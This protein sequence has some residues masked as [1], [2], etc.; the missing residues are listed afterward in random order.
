M[1]NQEG[2]GGSYNSFFGY[3]AGK[4]TTGTEN[5]CLGYGSGLLNTAAGGNTFFGHTAGRDNQGSGS[6]KNTYL[7]WQSGRLV[8]SGLGNTYMGWRSGNNS[9]QQNSNTFL[10]A[11]SGDNSNNANSNA[12]LGAFSMVDGS[13]SDDCVA[14][15]VQ[16]RGNGKDFNT[17]VGWNTRVNGDNNVLV[18]TGGAD[19][20]TNSNLGNRNVVVGNN[21]ELN[22][23]SAYLPEN[24]VFL[25]HRAGGK[26]K[27][28]HRNTLLGN[29]AGENLTDGNDNVF[30]G[31][32]A[33]SAG[34]S[35]MWK[36]IVSDYSWRTPLIDGDFWTGKVTFRQL[37]VTGGG[38]M[39]E[40]FQS[41][42]KPGP[43][44]VV[45]LDSDK[46]G[47]LRIARE[48]YDTKVAGIV[49]GAGGIRPGFK[50]RKQ[51]THLDGS[52]DLA[53]RGRVYCRA[54]AAYGAIRPGDLLTTSGTPGHAMRA[55][56]YSRGRGAFVGKAMSS[57]AE[58]RGLVLVLVRD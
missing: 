44:M 41:E 53:L 12:G 42:E 11:Q 5:T 19:Y 40:G 21:P 22:L 18:G 10:G 47:K 37:I 34:T 46:E 52:I 35:A 33:Q 51:E 36:F 55:A 45:S 14:M 24:N 1:S 15:G 54:D 9:T 4:V 25:G 13:G 23:N 48:A 38:D 39:A 31:H 7:G 49:S 8:Q 26:L 50:L 28:S 3:Q 16:S 6:S 17:L 32:E 20:N 58:G 27:V 56:D 29:R 30:I 2:T 43:G 57:L